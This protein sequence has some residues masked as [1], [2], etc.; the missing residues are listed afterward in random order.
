[1]DLDGL[2]NH[3]ILAQDLI[4]LYIILQRC[5]K[6]CRTGKTVNFAAAAAAVSRLQQHQQC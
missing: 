2:K 5:W 4:F 3:Q 6:L 1:M